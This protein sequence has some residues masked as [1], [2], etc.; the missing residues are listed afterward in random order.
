MSLVGADS[1]L[2]LQEILS[3]V[4][5]KICIGETQNSF[6]FTSVTTDSR[7]VT[8]GSLFVPLIG[9][10]QDGHKYIIQAVRKGATAVLAVQSSYEALPA[11]DRSEIEKSCTVIFTENTMYA[12]QAAA[13]C[14]VKKFPEL[15][16][17]GI[18][19]SNGKTTTKEIAVAVLSRH[20]NVIAT[21]GNFNSE[22]GLP[23]SVFNIRKEHQVGI[24]EMGMNRRGEISELAA[25]LM[26]EY[27]VITNIGTAHIGILESKEAIAEEKKQIFSYLSVKGVG[28][29]PEKDE[30]ASF[31]QNVSSGT[32]RLFGK[33]TQAAS[34]TDVESAGLDGT[35]FRYYGRQVCFPLPGSYNFNNMLAVISLA[36]TL[37]LSKDEIVAGV[38]SV[39]P[40]FGR[41]NI[42]RGKFT[43]VE[44]CYNANA[45]SMNEAV[46]FYGS[47]N[48]TGKKIFVLADM[49]ELGEESA[50][51]HSEIGKKAAE[52]GADVL[53]FVGWEMMHGAEAAR[54]AAASMKAD[55]VS[56][57]NAVT[58]ISES[59]VSDAA[60]AALTDRLCSEVAE[61]D[62][63]LVKG[64][65]GMRLERITEV[66]RKVAAE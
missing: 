47:I 52:S 24:F 27:A 32:V 30:F 58:V 18:T 17:V 44:D 40:L 28:F 7:S 49:L 23:L 54:M 46:S 3:A 14:Y 19:G 45:E 5:A 1:L 66:L 34:V 48:I 64:S 2:S 11:A 25:V 55:S 12:L 8:D 15:I 42:S 29:V 41:S 33:I 39:R 26:P 10:N 57:D 4:K 21:Q 20:F 43:V 36:E 35:M 53:V 16:R 22:T 37:G 56:S 63:V 38:E 50:R 51:I 60:V 13:A 61:G 62:L 9:E 59:D 6:S 65:R 31:L